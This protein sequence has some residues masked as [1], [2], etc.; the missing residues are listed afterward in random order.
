MCEAIAET[1]LARQSG[2]S[3]TNSFWGIVTKAGKKNCDGQEIVGQILYDNC[4]GS[5]ETHADVTSAC[6]AVTGILAAR[7]GVCQ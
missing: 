2:T 5:S 3:T 4:P 1:G 6:P 7:T